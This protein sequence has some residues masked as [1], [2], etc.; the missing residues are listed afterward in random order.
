LKETSASLHGK[1]ACG[2]G[3]YQRKNFQGRM[4]SQVF[5]LYN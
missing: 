2:E 1:G 5:F 3:Y 4:V